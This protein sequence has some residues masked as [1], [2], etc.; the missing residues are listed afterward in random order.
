MLESVLLAL[1]GGMAGCL[2]ALP[3]NGIATGTTNLE[4]FSEMVFYFTITPGLMLEGLLF[5]ACMGVVGG[6]LPAWA[7]SRQPVLAAMRQV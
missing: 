3:M 4:T 1:L 7:A 2:L 6:F 5:A